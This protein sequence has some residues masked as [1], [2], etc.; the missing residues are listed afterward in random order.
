[1]TF[2]AKDTIYKRN[3]K[4]DLKVISDPS[5]NVRLYRTKDYGQFVFTDENRVIRQSLLQ[6]LEKSIVEHGYYRESP[7][8]VV[9]RDDK[10]VIVNGQHRFTVCKNLEIDVLYTIIDGDPSEISKTIR[11]LNSH[12][13]VWKDEDYLRHFISLGYTPYLRLRK[14]ML[15]QDIGLPAALS[16][17]GAEA[18]IMTDTKKARERFRSNNI[19]FGD[20]EVTASNT[21]MIQVNEIRNLHERLMTFRRDPA[22]IK[23]LL[24]MTASRIYEH[25]RFLRNLQ[26]NIVSCV[27][28]TSL[29][30]YFQVL[31]TIYNYRRNDRSRVTLSRKGLTMT[32][33]NMDEDGE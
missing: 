25:D 18:G 1:M 11:V 17:L 2:T 27:K 10:L 8:C 6:E 33:G 30:K 7:I 9:R 31:E 12:A 23:A 32:V 19:A 20:K 26:I 4:G 13:R 22:F 21:L 3:N 14:F 5:E 15:D 16:I 24:V 29:G 28:C